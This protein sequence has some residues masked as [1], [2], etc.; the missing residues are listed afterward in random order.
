MSCIAS[1]NVRGIN[2]PAK[3]S[4]VRTL[5][6]KYHIGLV[7]ILE[8]KVRVE[9]SSRVF[10]SCCPD[11]SWS[12]YCFN[13]GEGRRSRILILWNPGCMGVKIWY[14]SDQ[15]IICDVVWNGQQAMVGFVYAQNN[16]RDRRRLWDDI[17]IAMPRAPGPWLLLGDFNCIRSPEEKLNGAVVREADIIELSEFLDQSGMTDLA[18]SGNFYTWFDKHQQGRRI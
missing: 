14:A 18:S 17:R 4:E 2:S 11:N 16:Q 13:E 10:E 6:Q 7:G 15:V 5:I 8:A 9:G 12:S 3:Q 1:W